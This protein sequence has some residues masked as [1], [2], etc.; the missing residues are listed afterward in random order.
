MDG[1][2]EVLI[3][4]CMKKALGC[5]VTASS[6][7]ILQFGFCN[8][9]LTANQQLPTN[10]STISPFSSSIFATTTSAPAAFSTPI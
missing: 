1:V 7:Y 8:I 2:F 5:E 9:P 3:E 4:V 10:Q 6:D